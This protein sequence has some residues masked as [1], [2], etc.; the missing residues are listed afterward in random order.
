MI[1][2]VFTED[3]FIPIMPVAAEQTE[4]ISSKNGYDEMMFQPAPPN[5]FGI[6][7][8][9]MLHRDAAVMKSAGMPPPG[10]AS[11]SIPRY[12]GTTT[13]RLNFLASAAEL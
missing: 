1:W 13:P 11:S 8:E 3:F 12:A 9:K 10:A 5:I 6:Q 2:S 7:R 4:A